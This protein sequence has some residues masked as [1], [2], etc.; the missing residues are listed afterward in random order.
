MRLSLR[1]RMLELST[2][3]GLITLTLVV[4]LV[5]AASDN[6]TTDNVVWSYW[7]GSLAYSGATQETDT[8]HSYY[9]RN[10]TGNEIKLGWE[11]SHKVLLGNA[12]VFNGT[13]WD[14]GSR[15]TLA[16]GESHSNSKLLRKYPTGLQAGQNYKLTAYTAVR[17]YDDDGDQMFGE[18]EDDGEEITFMP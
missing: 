2:A 18:G 14:K 15:I 8:R 12:L 11:F 4:T 7:V 5:Y 9:V 10:N 13:E 1:S 6:S 16:N 17:I 3:I